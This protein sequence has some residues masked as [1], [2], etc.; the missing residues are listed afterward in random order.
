MDVRAEGAT[1]QS[2][3]GELVCHTPFPSRPLGLYGDREGRRFHDTY[4]RQHPGVWT[5]GDFI[6]FTANAGAGL[7]GRTDNVLNVRGVRVG[8]AEIYTILADIREISEALAVEQRAPA[9]PGGSRMVMLVVLRQGRLLDGPLSLRIKKEL[10]RRGSPAHVPEIIAQVPELPRTYSGKR[11]EQAARAALNGEEVANLAALANPGCIEGLR[12]HPA[13]ALAEAR[14]LPPE[15]PFEEQLCAIWEEIFRVAPVGLDD[16]FFDLGGRSL[17]AFELVTKIRERLGRELPA[18]MLL[19]AP[20]ITALAAALRED[21]EPPRF[22]CVVP[23]KLGGR[24]A[25]LFIVHGFAGNPF[26]LLKIAWAIDADRPIYALQAR[27]LDPRQEPHRRIEDMAEHYIRE[28]G[29]VQPNGPYWLSGF[30]SGGL[31][32]YEMA[33]QLRQRGEQIAFVGLLDTLVGERNLPVAPRI[34]LALSRAAWLGRKVWQLPRDDK[35]PYLEHIVLL[36]VDARARWRGWHSAR[37]SAQ[38]ERLPAHFLRVRDCGWVAFEAYRPSAFPG[39][40]TFFRAMRPYPLAFDPLPVWRRVARTVEIYDVPGTHES[41]IEEPNVAVLGN[42]MRR[43]LERG[44]TQL[45]EGELTTDG[46]FDLAPHRRAS[47]LGRH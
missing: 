1:T 31:I 39:T 40:V 42:L 5:H 17:L 32:A 41:L 7:H 46:C 36:V 38:E 9:E 35:L 4:F 8:P 16:N 43:C 24:D 10:A 20:T 11:S 29:A 21:R 3:V 22:S 19:H 14:A 45:N 33:R 15:A 6:E 13:L 2:P 47:D 37:R 44:A 25:P 12:R 23:L 26:E 30:S 34:G 27:G 28:I 18:T